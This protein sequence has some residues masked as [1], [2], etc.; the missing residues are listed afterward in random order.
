[1]IWISRL[2][3]RDVQT[4]V[5]TWNNQ[6]NW[7]IG[8]LLAFTGRLEIP[9]PQ[10]RRF[11]DGFERH[12]HSRYRQPRHSLVLLGV[13]Y[14]S[15]GYSFTRAGLRGHHHPNILVR[16]GDGRLYR[17][18]GLHVLGLLFLAGCLSRGLEMLH[19]LVVG[20]LLHLLN[21]ARCFFASRAWDGFVVLRGDVPFV[22]AVSSGPRIVRQPMASYLF[23]RL[24][25][26]LDEFASEV[27][28]LV[29]GV[30]SYPTDL[31]VRPIRGVGLLCAVIPGDV[32]VLSLL[33][34]FAIRAN[35]ALLRHLPGGVVVHFNFSVDP[36]VLHNGVLGNRSRC[37]AQ[38]QREER[39]QPPNA[40]SKRLL[41][42]RHVVFSS[43]KA[44]KSRKVDIWEHS[45]LNCRR[46]GFR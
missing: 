11:A 28:A 17:S 33:L 42:P 41:I 19:H 23:A 4:E 29:V 15:A 6:S 39:R 45:E 26:N 8:T 25:E 34:E 21:S 14:H 37:A 7:S 12:C 30:A 46:W 1:M 36:V 16:R 43:M 38:Q 22:A 3:K 10:P 32:L 24:V 35:G 2:P 13:L 9:T 18:H 27:R 5:A 40:Q 31:G 44:L 20:E